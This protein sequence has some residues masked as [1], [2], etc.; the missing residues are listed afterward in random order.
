[1]ERQLSQHIAPRRVRR[2]YERGIARPL[3]L[4]SRLG[5]LLGRLG[6]LL[7]RLGSLLEASWA[8]LGGSRLQ[9]SLAQTAG[10]MPY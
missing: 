2:D 9:I 5:H 3:P 8:V 4:L 6:A 1:M 10:S 7:R